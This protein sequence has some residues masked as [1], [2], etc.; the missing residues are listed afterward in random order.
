MF[1]NLDHAY[2]TRSAQIRKHTEISNVKTLL[3]LL[4]PAAAS[5]I[6]QT[7]VAKALFS[8]V[9]S[10]KQQPAQHRRT[11]ASWA[12]SGFCPNGGVVAWLGCI[13]C[14]WWLLLGN[15]SHLLAVSSTRDPRAV[16]P[17]ASGRHIVGLPEAACWPWRWARTNSGRPRRGLAQGPPRRNNVAALAVDSA[18]PAV[19]Q[20]LLANRASETD[21]HQ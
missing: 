3:C 4:W 6:A 21:Q 7:H 19:G 1:V 15:D 12:W 18:L 8:M 13:S 11:F 14:A 17:P 9:L 16:P 2:W 10:T 5:W 20:E